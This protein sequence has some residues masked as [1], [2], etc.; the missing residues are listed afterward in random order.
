MVSERGKRSGLRRLPDRSSTAKAPAYPRRIINV[1]FFIHSRGIQENSNRKQ[2]HREVQ[3]PPSI[4]ISLPEVIKY[5]ELRKGTM[6]LEYME[7]YASYMQD[8]SDFCSLHVIPNI[9]TTLPYRMPACFPLKDVLRS[10]MRAHKNGSNLPLL[11]PYA[12]LASICRPKGPRYVCFLCYIYGKYRSSALDQGTPPPPTRSQTPSSSHD[13]TVL[14]RDPASA[15]RSL[16]L[17][18]YCRVRC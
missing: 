16:G 5:S 2:K 9:L 15:S 17:T 8:D 18:V 1:L 14:P 6:T 4:S 10:W 3:T 12:L 7:S 13:L 11:S